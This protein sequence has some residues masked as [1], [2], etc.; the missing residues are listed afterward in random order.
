MLSLV[1]DT[2]TVIWYLAKSPRLSATARG[3]MKE[4]IRSGAAVLVPAIC[5]VEL[6]YLIEKGRMPSVVRQRL[7]DHLAQ[8]DSGFEVATLDI[9]VAD[10]L[11]QVPR[12]Q[13]PDMPDR[14]IAATAFHLGLPLVSRDRHMKAAGID[15][16]W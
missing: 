3:M 12:Q 5:L 1:A 10:S 13:V 14:I 6:T 8:E 16:I 11:A 7:M 15:V 2:H 4:A 9:G